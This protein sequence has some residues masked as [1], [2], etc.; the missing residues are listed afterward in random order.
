MHCCLFGLSIAN[1]GARSRQ[2]RLLEELKNSKSY[3]RFCIL[4]DEPTQ[5][6]KTWKDAFSRIK[7][8]SLLL[9]L[10]LKN[11]SFLQ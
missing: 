9:K 1:I 2:I 6:A 4:N 7:K 11:K 3:K 10:R 5:P 8:R